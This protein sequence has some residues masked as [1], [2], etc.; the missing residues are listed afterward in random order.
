MEPDF[1][2]EGLDIEGTEE[3]LP[4]FDVMD[5]VDEY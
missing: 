4:D 1:D 5:D 3:D 2:Y